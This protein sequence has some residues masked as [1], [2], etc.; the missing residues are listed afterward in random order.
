VVWWNGVAVVRWDSGKR[1]EGSGGPVEHWAG[2]GS[3][4]ETL[5]KRTNRRSEA[6]GL[7]ALSTRPPARMAPWPSIQIAL[8]LRHSCHF[9]WFVDEPLPSQPHAPAICPSLAK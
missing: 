9:V 5:A 4:Q 3:S 2:R 1:E 6:D 7:G 8:A